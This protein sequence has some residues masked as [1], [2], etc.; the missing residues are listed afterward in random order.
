VCVWNVRRH[1]VRG[2]SGCLVLL[3]VSLLLTHAAMLR[4]RG[5]AVCVRVRSRR[6]LISRS[7][8]TRDRYSLGALS[9]PRAVHKCWRRQCTACRC[10]AG[11]ADR[12]QRGVV[13]LSLWC[14]CC[15]CCS[16]GITEV[17]GWRLDDAAAAVAAGTTPR[18]VFELRTPAPPGLRA[19][20]Q[21]AETNSLCWSSSVRATAL[22]LCVSVSLSLYVCVSLCLGRCVSVSVHVYLCVQSRACTIVAHTHVSSSA[23]LGHLFSATG[24]NNAYAWDLNAC[25]APVAC[26][27][28]GSSFV[29][30][31]L[32]LGA[33]PCSSAS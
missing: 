15:C 20:F 32:L 1:M 8:R 11:V 10:H 25:A 24:D 3:V 18:P 4:R 16:G 31:M 29:R 14:C 22:C 2:I 30:L 23:Q 17:R 27:S 19:A 5:P 28:G 13:A 33:S 6:F 9:R 7:R 21:V 26:Y 12:L